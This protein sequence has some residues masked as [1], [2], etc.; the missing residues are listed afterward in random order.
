MPAKS[1]FNDRSFVARVAQ[2]VYVED[3][4]RG[5]V[6]KEENISV[7]TVTRVLR[8]AREQGIISFVINKGAASLKLDSD[9]ADKL[10]EKFAL[11]HAIVVQSPEEN[12]PVYQPAEDDRLHFLLGKAL[13]AYLYTY[14]RPG[15]HIWTVGGRGTY[16][17]GSSLPIEGSVKFKDVHVTAIAGRMATL[18]HDPMVMPPST[19]D[20][21]DAA[22]RL[23]KV[24]CDD[25]RDNFHALNQPVAYAGGYADRARD[26]DHLFCPDGSLKH[27]STIALCGV[28]RV[29]GMHMYMHPEGDHLR[30]LREELKILFNLL[31]GYKKK[32]GNWEFFPLGDLAN[33]LFLTKEIKDKE[34]RM[35][36]NDNIGEI[37]KKIVGLKLSQ[38]AL[39]RVTIL[40]AG[41][42][43]KCQ[44]IEKILRFRKLSGESL[45]NILCTDSQVAQK[46]LN[47]GLQAPIK[48]NEF[49]GETESELP[50]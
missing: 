33:R 16:F 6:A 15:D 27:P 35:H 40:N 25:L 48:V 2:K 23:A 4:S 13:G 12:V 20:A 37:N 30:P 5:S 26:F 24:F 7:A 14:I 41:G 19:A 32:I 1:K 49:P 45:I 22:F 34:V 11:T 8:Y 46:L 44:A 36:I 43:H 10:C 47:I 9:L 17:V 39:A 38:L 31:G 3:R 50:N 18:G 21:D 28:G 29:G 42:I